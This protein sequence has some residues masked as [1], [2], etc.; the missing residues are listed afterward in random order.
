VAIR[1]QFMMSDELRSLLEKHQADL[2]AQQ[3]EAAANQ[4]GMR[5]MLQDGILKVCA[6]ETTLEE[7]FRVVG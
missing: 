6:G 5:T 2:S 7:I 3:I 1:E 4:S